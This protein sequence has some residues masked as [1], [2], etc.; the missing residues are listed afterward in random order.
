MI[1]VICLD[2]RR[3]LVNA[4]QIETIEQTP[5]TIISFMS[6][7]KLLVRLALECKRVGVGD[8]P[9]V[10]H[11]KLVMF[12]ER[13]HHAQAY[14][15]SVIPYNRAMPKIHPTAIVEGMNTGDITLADDVE[16][17]PY[18]VLRGKIELGAGTVLIANV[19][20]QGP[21]RMGAGNA[22]YPGVAIGFAP[23]D[24]GFHHAKDGAGIVIGDANSFREHVTIH[25][26]TR[27]DP[28]DPVAAVWR[29][30]A[31]RAVVR[32]AFANIDEP[33]IGHAARARGRTAAIAGCRG[34]PAG[35]D[36]QAGE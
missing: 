34:H 12:G 22:C 2:G 9:E 35:R 29:G 3:A 13:L 8:A 7:H 11:A 6:G 16:I 23:Q 30:E 24:K 26:A 33:L 31:L 19:H 5:D 28:D 14:G 10:H 21:L 1:N 25:R 4:D 36:A 27:D 17:G 18:C 20:L 15:A 32:A